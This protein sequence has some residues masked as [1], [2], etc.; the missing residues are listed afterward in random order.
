MGCDKYDKT[1]YIIIGV[2]IL[3]VLAVG[4]FMCF[5]EPV[6]GDHRNINTGFQRT[7]DDIESVKGNIDSSTESVERVERSVDQCQEAV[8]SV[9]S[10]NRG[11]ERAVNDAEAGNSNAESAI[12]ACVEYIDRCTAVLDRYAESR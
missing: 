1:I 2:G 4:W 12:S 3:L 6:A 11:A 7:A 9:E 8:S 5:H 10:A